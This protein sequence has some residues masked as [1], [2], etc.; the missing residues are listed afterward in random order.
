MA[1]LDK[2]ESQLDEVLV[3]NAPVQLPNDAKKWIAEYI[4]YISLVA[5]LLTLWGAYQLYR[6]ATVVNRYA[7]V[8]NEWSRAFGVDN[9]ASTSRL[10]IGVWVAV[11]VLAVE[12]ALWVAS[13]PGSKAKKKSGWNFM[14][15]ALLAN[16]VYGLAVLFTDYAGVSNFV[17]Y[18]VGTVIGLYFLFQIRSEFT[19]KTAAPK[20]PEKK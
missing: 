10:T 3:K 8:V 18:L 5:G 14:F 15:M 19:G 17:F 13:Y 1:A 16:A 4:P 7:D 11:I 9:Y 12:G 2:L 20:T 6:W